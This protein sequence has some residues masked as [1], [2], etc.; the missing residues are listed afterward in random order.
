LYDE[1]RIATGELMQMLALAPA[2]PVLSLE[3][4][5]LQEWEQDYEYWLRSANEERGVTEVRLQR[6]APNHCDLLSKWKAL[7]KRK[8]HFFTSV[9]PI[10][11]VFATVLQLLSATAVAVCRCT[12]GWPY[13]L[14]EEHGLV[15]PPVYDPA[16]ETFV[17][18]RGLTGR[19]AEVNY[20]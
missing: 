16:Y 3:E 10:V 17:Q 5:F 13:R 1:L 12:P 19:E 7:H 18:E 9:G 4:V 8:R 20:W 11:S 6:D 2:Q 14:Y 15:W